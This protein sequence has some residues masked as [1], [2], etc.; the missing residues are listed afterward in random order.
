MEMRISALVFAFST[1]LSL[2]PLGCS[3]PA[4]PVTVQQMQALTNEVERLTKDPIMKIE[5]LDVGL[6]LVS[7]ESLAPGRKQNFCMQRMRRGWNPVPS[8]TTP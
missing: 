4:G 6:L 5:H 3:P 8:S 7:T 1:P 2:F